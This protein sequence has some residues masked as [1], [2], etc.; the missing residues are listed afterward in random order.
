MKF[1]LSYKN[2]HH[3]RYFI[4]LGAELI[5]A[6]HDVNIVH[7]ET[8]GEA[9]AGA[10]VVMEVNRGRTDRIP[11]TAV[12]IPWIQDH[13]LWEA[14]GYDECA[15]PRDMIYTYGHGPIIGV[16]CQDWPNY[17]GSLLVAVDA[18]LLAYPPAAQNLDLSIVGYI[19]DPEQRWKA[20]SL[21][22]V[23]VSEIARCIAETMEAV[24][25]PLRGE[26]D[27]Q[28]TAYQLWAGMER[29]FP[30]IWDVLYKE[31]AGYIVHELARM[32]DRVAIA[33]LILSVSENV[34]FRGFNWELWPEFAKW[35]KPFYEDREQV[36]NLYQ[37]SRINVHNNIFGFA[38]HDRVLEAMA[39]GGFVMANESPHLG[40]A[41]Q[42]TECFAPGFHYGEYNAD[43]FCEQARK[44]LGNP[45][46]RQRGIVESRKII[47]DRHLWAHRAKQ[48]LRDLA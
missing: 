16:P 22:S 2:S 44:W 31:Y 29:K 35:G 48:L 38:L 36:L 47:K 11:R 25:T 24:Y 37:R 4:G 46:M 12:H 23:S 19:S 39:V 5:L 8:P 20:R 6:G 32:R 26:L 21:E 40:K 42:M 1:V 18:K 17:R 15:H 13:I 27:Q 41:G 43:T 14:P 30:D 9:F 28:L 45:Q 33:R 34:E 10:D 7:Q 3:R